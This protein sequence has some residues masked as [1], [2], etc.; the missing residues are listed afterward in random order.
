[1]VAF[2]VPCARVKGVVLSIVIGASLLP[3]NAWAAEEGH[4][5]EEPGTD[6]EGAVEGGAK[7][8]LLGGTCPSDY[9]T[10]KSNGWCVYETKWSSKSK[11][12]SGGCS[13]SYGSSGGSSGSKLQRSGFYNG[14]CFSFKGSGSSWC[15]VQKSGGAFE[16]N[17]KKC[18][19]YDGSNVNWCCPAA[20]CSSSSGGS[21]SGG[22]AGGNEWVRIHNSYR[23]KH[24]AG[25]LQWDSALATKAQNWANKIK[26]WNSLTHSASYKTNPPSG[27]NLARGQSSKAKAMKAWYD[28]YYLWKRGNWKNVNGIGHFTA[29]IW[30]GANRIGCGQAGK[31]YVCEYGS[32]KCRSTGNC[33]CKFD[34]PPCIPN[35]NDRL[36]SGGSCVAGK[37]EVENVGVGLWQ[38]APSLFAP[39]LLVLAAVAGVI[40]TVVVVRRKRSRLAVQARTI[41]DSDKPLYDQEVE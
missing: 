32:S 39:V 11:W 7:E 3:G 36:C 18:A 40:A 41:V 6:I 13:S 31:F 23:R 1:M 28:E 24:G 15:Y 35:Y 2:V 30:K 16:T 33:D 17:K 27:E 22:G 10:C 21:S 9:P 37:E 20:G 25:N 19:S 5:Y 12:S 34:N 38:A 29:M 26:S 4:H 14:A 8:R